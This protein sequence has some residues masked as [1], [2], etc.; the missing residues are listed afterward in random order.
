MWHT[1]YPVRA[2]FTQPAAPWNETVN[3]L[4]PRVVAP[5]ATGA[6]LYGRAAASGTGAYLYGRAA[7]SGTGAYLYGRAAASG[8]GVVHQK[9]AVASASGFLAVRAAVP[10]G[11]AA[12]S[13]HIAGRA[14][15]TGFSVVSWNETKY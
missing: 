15:P 4:Q 10:T 7:A 6:Y 12:A 3:D 9:R 8:T 2:Q 14:V 11:Y 1:T 5:T 13:G